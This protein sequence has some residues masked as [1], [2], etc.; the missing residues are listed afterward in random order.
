MS[1]QPQ[2]AEPDDIDV[3]HKSLDVMSIGAHVDRADGI[4]ELRVV[5]AKLPV[6]SKRELILRANKLALEFENDDMGFDILF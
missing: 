5:F 6:S 3:Y 2:I 1:S 4:T